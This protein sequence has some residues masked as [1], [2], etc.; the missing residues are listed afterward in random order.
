[1]NNNNLYNTNSFIGITH[2][3]YFKTASNAL[4]KAINSL[5]LNSSNYTSNVN[6]N[7]SNYTSNVSNILNTNSSNYTNILRY[8]VNKWINEQ[9]DELIPGLNITNTYIS[10]SNI[11]GYIKFWTKDSEKVYT[12]IN[13]DGKLQYITITK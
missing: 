3:D 5:E 13:Q 4:A 6:I 12:R 8:D 11:G 2:N 7:S 1:M 10:N 9:T